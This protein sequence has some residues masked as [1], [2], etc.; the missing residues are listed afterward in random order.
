MKKSILVEKIGRLELMLARSMR[1]REALRSKLDNKKRD[2]ALAKHA[3]RYARAKYYLERGE[4]LGEIAEELGI[5]TTTLRQ[6]M[7]KIEELI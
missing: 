4:P 1:Q 6:S 7:K 2:A 3:I 5:S